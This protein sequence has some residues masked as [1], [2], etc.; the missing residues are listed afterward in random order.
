MKKVLGTKLSFHNEDFMKKKQQYA[1]MRQ[2][3]QKVLFYN[4]FSN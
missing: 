1:L 4:I 3:Y 2:S